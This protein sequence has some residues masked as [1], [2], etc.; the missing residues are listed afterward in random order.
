MQQ[1]QLAWALSV[2]LSGNKCNM[3]PNSHLNHF[4]WFLVSWSLGFF[5]LRPLAC[6]FYS[7]F[8]PLFVSLAVFICCKQLR[9]A[10]IFSFS[11]KNSEIW[12]STNSFFLFYLINCYW[13]NNHHFS[14]NHKCVYCL[15]G[16][17]SSFMSGKNKDGTQ[18]KLE[19]KNY[20]EYSCTMSD[21]GNIKRLQVSRIRSNLFFPNSM[22]IK[23]WK[24]WKSNWD[25]RT[26]AEKR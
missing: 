22:P 2:W 12:T 3:V 26:C 4:H 11:Q 15:R 7:T 17:N 14:V 23:R 21:L 16:K 9:S 5:Q 25:F 20:L 13:N 19:K 6:K 18:N 24:N 8:N 1:L 10:F